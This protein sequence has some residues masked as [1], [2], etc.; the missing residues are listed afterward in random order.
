MTDDVGQLFQAA[1]THQAAGRT[2][3]AEI[4]LGSI[5]AVEPGHAEAIHMLGLLAFL[6][7]D[8][9]VAARLM[10]HSIA[11]AVQPPTH[12]WSNLG[13]TCRR[14]GLMD[15]ALECCR[16]AVATDPD[17][18]SAHLNLG[19]TLRGSGDPAAAAAA[20]QDAIRCNPGLWRAH[21]SRASALAAAGRT[22][23]GI[24]C[25]DAASALLGD[26]PDRL[27]TAAGT[28]VELGR[29]TEAVECYRR[30]LAIRPGD[31]EILNS[32]GVLFDRAGR[33]MAAIEVYGKAIAAA[34]GL[35][36]LY[37]NL[38]NVLRDIGNW[39]EAL[40]HY[41]RALE[42]RPDLFVTQSNILFTRLF[43][44]AATGADLLAEARSWEAGRGTP[45]VRPPPASGPD[46]RLRV[47]YV[48]P[49]FKEHA[50]TF[51]VEPLLRA[52]D[53][54]RVEVFCYS[55]TLRPDD[56]TKRLRALADGWR[57]TLGVDD[58]R[59]AEMI[60]AD[61]IDVLVDLAGHTAGNR[62]LAMAGRPA[63][64]QVSFILGY[65]G[66]TGLSWMDAIVTDAV[67]TPPGFESHF[68]EKVI[69]LPGVFAAFQPRESWPEVFPLPDGPPLLGC[70]T[71]PA[72]VD[73]GQ[74]ELWRRVLEAMPDARI[75]FKHASYDSPDMAGHW[76]RL[77]GKVADRAIFEGV[78]GGW[79]A[80][81][82]V[83]GRVTVM[84]DSWPASS[85]SASV[86]MLWMGLPVVTLAG[87]H[88]NQRFTASILTAAG[89]SDLAAIDGDGYVRLITTLAGDR[90]RLADLR[91]TLRDRVRNS[92]LTDAEAYARGVE[93]AYR[94]LWRDACGA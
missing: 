69:R 49:D 1:L 41:R 59:L 24:R 31:A 16:K 33:K 74:V 12:F 5:L 38:G 65:G 46:R 42:L 25:L 83:Y 26:D 79:G 91:A 35:G 21:T 8:Y 55:D 56:T 58:A 61:G 10:R 86:I 7:G 66:T 40:A 43:D 30:A 28:W 87:G 78:P 89:L 11:L 81:M 70:F 9:A 29:P 57:D 15:E 75:L 85:A 3:D 45:A 6:R 14:I 18:A 90:R 73:G 20:F 39:P 17:N 22:D 88:A 27:S 47:G 54:R 50:V 80:N 67:L 84:L 71:D 48:S 51:F 63:P 93:A 53:R 60:R 92:P 44:P 4:A 52:H 68:S 37:S 13:E 23:E 76:R 77:F 2:R 82:D 62:L 19:L 34:P 72:R 32:L 36:H 94:A 64:V